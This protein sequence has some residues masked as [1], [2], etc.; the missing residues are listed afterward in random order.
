MK[1]LAVSHQPE[2]GRPVASVP[3][4]N[5][6]GF[7]A[8]GEISLLTAGPGTANKDFRRAL[9]VLPD[10]GQAYYSIGLAYRR[11][12]TASKQLQDL[13]TAEKNLLRSRELAPQNPQ[14]ALQLGILYSQDLAQTDTENQR[15]YLRK[16]IENWED[17]IKLGGANTGQVRRWIEEITSGR[18][19]QEARAGT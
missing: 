17:Y 5:V 18:K 10:Y 4:K 7:V 19:V 16:A 6:R 2:T 1:I 12:F 8:R 14:F 15:E 9:E 11:K 3:V 13:K